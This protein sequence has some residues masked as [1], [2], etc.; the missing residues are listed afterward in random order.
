MYILSD[1][2]YTNDVRKAI[3]DYV[4]LL[5]SMDPYVIKKD[6]LPK[7]D[8][9][10]VGDNMDDISVVANERLSKELDNLL[11]RL[12]IKFEVKNIELNNNQYHIEILVNNELIEI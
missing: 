5:F 9:H 7:I 2:T 8:R 12:N 3:K 6:P 1:L 11:N 10:I 4:N